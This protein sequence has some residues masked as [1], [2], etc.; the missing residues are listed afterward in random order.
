MGT[1]D[2]EPEG[3]Q[4]MEQETGAADKGWE[5]AEI[6]SGEPNYNQSGFKMSSPRDSPFNVSSFSA[7]ILSNYK[8][9]ELTP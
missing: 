1:N 4:G 9:L 7:N 3:E 5:C 8:K 2:G 6:G